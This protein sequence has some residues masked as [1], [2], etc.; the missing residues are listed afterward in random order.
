MSALTISELG[1]YI[2]GKYADRPITPMKLQKLAY[3]VKVWTLIAGYPIISD[4]GFDK[5]DHG[6][7]NETLYHEYKTYRSRPIKD[8]V[9]LPKLHPDAQEIVDFIL[10]NYID[11]SA[12]DLSAMTHGEAPWLETNNNR[13]ISEFAIKRY[14]SQEP[15]A[16]NFEHFDP[17]NNPFYLLRDQAWYAFTMDMSSVDKQLSATMPSYAEY[18]ALKQQAKADIAALE[19]A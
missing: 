2:L 19:R 4:A 14:Y 10:E 7:V 9:E 17:E 12:F 15:F 3:Y 11:Y 5:W 13:Q 18:K 8:D 1:R 6:P 16:K